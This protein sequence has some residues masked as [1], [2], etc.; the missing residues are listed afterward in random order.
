MSFVHRRSEPLR[1]CRWDRKTASSTRSIAAVSLARGLPACRFSAVFAALAC[2][3]SYFR[4]VVGR[5]PSILT[6]VSHA[7]KCGPA[8]ALVKLLSG[9]V[10]LLLLATEGRQSQSAGGASGFSVGGGW[11]RF[12][13]SGACLW[14]FNGPGI[15]YVTVSSRTQQ[16]QEIARQFFGSGGISFNGNPGNA[17]AGNAARN[18]RYQAAPQRL[19]PAPTRR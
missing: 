8:C 14:N 16:Q 6:G 2:L 11:F 3:A 15:R 5:M 19:T 7:E 9:F 17:L 13:P 10:L 1:R 12:V 4:Y 18:V